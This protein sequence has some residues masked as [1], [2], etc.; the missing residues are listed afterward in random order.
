[1]PLQLEPRL[2]VARHKN[3]FAAFGR[4]YILVEPLSAFRAADRDHGGMFATGWD[5]VKTHVSR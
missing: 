5:Q 2:S 4:A 1:M 3:N